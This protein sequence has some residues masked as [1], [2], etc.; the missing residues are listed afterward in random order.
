[1]LGTLGVVL[2]AI[3]GLVL[4]VAVLFGTGIVKFDKTIAEYFDDG[5]D[6]S[7]SDKKF[8]PTTGRSD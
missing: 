2:C 7:E 8:I 4:C 3:F 1:L 6:G 5:W